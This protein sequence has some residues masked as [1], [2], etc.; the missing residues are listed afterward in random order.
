MITDRRRLRSDADLL[1]RRVGEAAAAGVDLVQVRERDLDARALSRLVTRCLEAARGTRTRVLVN[2][3][4]DVALSTGAHGVHL[5]S[6]S[7]AAARARSLAPVGFLIGRS[8]HAVDEAVRVAADGG[9]DYLLFG[10]V[11]ATSSKPGHTPAGVRMLAEVA[12]ATS[13][14]VLAVGGITAETMTLLA[15]CGS[16]GF[17]AIG[18]FADGGEG[19]ARQGLAAAARAFEKG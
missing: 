8:V 2:D 17:A 4:L 5:R 10:A 9:V 1:V 7:V 19:V 15:G 3:R 16:A 12:A 14:P 6:D 11:F 13:V 18:W